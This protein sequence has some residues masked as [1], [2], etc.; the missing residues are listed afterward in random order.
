MP[1][2]SLKGTISGRAEA[3]ADARSVRGQ[4]EL[5]QL[6]LDAVSAAVDSALKG[7]GISFEAAAS[8]N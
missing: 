2:Q 1:E 3:L 5:A 4:S 8:K 6:Q 7:A